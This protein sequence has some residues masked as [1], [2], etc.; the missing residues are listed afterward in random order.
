MAN[1]KTEKDRRRRRRRRRI[2][3]IVIYTA[4][5]VGLA[6]FFES[7]ATTT[8]IFVRHTER[9]GPSA[10]DPGLTPAGQRRAAELARQLVDADVVAGIDAIYSTPFRR[11]KET[12]QPIAEK[13][14][15]PINIY[16]PTGDDEAVV[17][18]MVKDHKGKIIL[19]VGHSNTLPTLIAALGA[20]KKVPPIAE[21]EY[22]NIYIISIPW[23]G[24]TKTI[25]LRFG[26]PY[27]GEP[28]EDGFEGLKMTEQQ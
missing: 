18:Q 4:I 23:F 19:I 1:G 15:L 3:A 6:W 25:R 14:N 20:S 13:L 2:Q 12:A 11:T 27:T 5:A 9:A 10:E 24:K 28:A 26:E 8:M 16:D 17:D 21:M 7:Q 22:D